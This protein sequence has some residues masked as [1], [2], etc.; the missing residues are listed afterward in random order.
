M[1]SRRLRTASSLLL[2]T[3]VALAI[4]LP[5][6]RQAFSLD[7]A[8]ELDYT[9]YEIQHPL[10][11]SLPNYDYFGVRF[12]NYFNTHPRFMSFYLS[13]V[14]RLSGGISELPVHLALTIF[15]LIGAVGMYF[16]GRRFRVSGL[17]AALLFLVSPMLMVDA[18]MET[19]DV[20]GVSL[21]IS[22]IAVFIFAV[23]R[24]SNLLLALSTLLMVLA[25]QTFFQGLAVLPLALAYLV[26]N[27]QF[28]LLNFLPV[29]A[30]GLLFGGYL[31]AIYAA[32]GQL[33][34]FSYRQHFNFNS[35]TSLLAQLRGNLTVL[36]GTLLFPLA[37]LAGFAARWTSALV[38]AAASL[39]TWSW[40]LV[41]FDLGQYSFSDML[42]LSIM[43]PV[44]IAVVY[45]MLERSL[46][47]I[48]RGQTRRVRQD[49]DALFLGVWFFGV[50]GYAILRLPYP[51]PRYL[52]PALPAVI[53]SLL[54]V[55]R[56]IV[57]S[58]WLKFSLALAAIAAT[59]GLS[60]VL[61]LTYRDIAN[62]ARQ[63]AEWAH[64]N[65]ANTQGVW[66]NGGFGF[67]Y[68]MKEY[69]YNL[70]PNVLNEFIAQTAQ[71]LREPHPGDLVIYSIQNGAWVP[72]PSV[73]KR[74]RPEKF[75]DFYNRQ[76]LAMPCAGTDKCWWNAGFLPYTIDTQGE[77]SDEVTV[78]RIAAR[79]NPLDASQL[80]IYSQ[81]G[82][83]HPDTLAGK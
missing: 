4:M 11:Q 46:A 43:L 5:F 58:H 27:R 30:T 2:I 64:S 68:Y 72:Y 71:P 31:L 15:P 10:A 60:T 3:G 63:A 38:F 7:G 41:K 1:K 40:S 70:T 74:L 80:R 83:T 32:Y 29:A 20:P 67:G 26:I 73:M 28:R 49:R 76:L 16:L 77:L 24:R 39:M 6:A 81:I 54:M 17:V 47:A 18:H 78:W 79:P 61:S 34:R 44:G 23:D 53:L 42:L 37:A 62:N 82:I 13:L 25:S 56:G 55:W 14:T 69:G 66:Y 19:V 9:Q 12:N 57:K 45:L 33:P 22:A 65:Y 8:L 48:F 51:A 52:L 59:M 35:T 36:G 50:L 75:I 21:W